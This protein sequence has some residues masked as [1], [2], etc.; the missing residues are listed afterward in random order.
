MPGMVMPGCHAPI[1][2]AG[3]GGGPSE[4]GIAMVLIIALSFGAWAIF[5]WRYMLRAKIPHYS[6]ISDW[7]GHAAHAPGMIVMAL[8]MMG[9]VPSIGPLWIYMAIYGACALVFLARLLTHWETVPRRA[10]LWH[11]FVNLS[12]VY[13]FSF[14]DI[15][16]VTVICLLLYA[17][18]LGVDAS[19]TLRAP[20][21]EPQTTSVVRLLNVLDSHGGL[22]LGFSMMLMLAIMQWAFP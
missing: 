9:A 18:M 1:P 17:A 10:E 2:F 15:E 3:A 19:R 21:A 6:V 7:L 8:L 16:L 14:G 4:L 5:A 13:M 22:A 11:V 12:M 20:G